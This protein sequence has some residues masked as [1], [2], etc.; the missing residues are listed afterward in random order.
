MYRPE[1]RKGLNLK[2]ED[3]GHSPYS[4]AFSEFNSF[5]Y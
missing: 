3:C 5:G 4:E 2:R 1:G